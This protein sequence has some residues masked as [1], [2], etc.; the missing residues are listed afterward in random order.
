MRLPFFLARRFVAGETLAA[1]IPVVRTLNQQGM[2]VTLARLGEHVHDAQVAQE[3]TDAYIH[4]LHVIHQEKLDATVS[5]KLSLIGQMFDLALC[6]ENLAR[7]MEVAHAHDI[8]VRLDMED[9]SLVPSTLE[10]FEYF[11]PRYPD[12][13]GPVLQAYLKRTARDVERMC[14][15]KAK[16]RLVKGAYKEPPEVAYQDIE[17]IREKFIEYMQALMVRARY[18]AIATHDDLLIQATK[19]FAA[20]QGISKDDFEF[21]MLYGLRQPTQRAL[22]KEGYHMRVY[23]PYGSDWFPYFYRRLRERKENIFFVLNNLFRK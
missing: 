6:R 16:V 9:S 18:P 8:F 1:A 14:E 4:L 13:I 20:E 21:Q 19:Q 2:H 12:H 5:L 10:L 17:T 22:V 11:Y 7:I 3:A 23:V 15:L